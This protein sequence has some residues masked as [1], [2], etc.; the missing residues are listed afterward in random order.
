M[1]REPANKLFNLC[2]L[3]GVGFVSAGLGAAQIYI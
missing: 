2:L 3:R 1:T